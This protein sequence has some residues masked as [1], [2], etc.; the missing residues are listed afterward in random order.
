MLP[1]S[2]SVA[3]ATGCGPTKTLPRGEVLL[4][5]ADSSSDLLTIGDHNCS[6]FV[7]PYTVII[8]TRSGA[9]SQRA[10]HDHGGA[11]TDGSAEPRFSWCGRFRIMTG[12]Q[13]IE[14]RSQFTA[15]RSGGFQEGLEADAEVLVVLEAIEQGELID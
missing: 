1:S 4:H 15:S 13:L 5:C 9:A 2:T 3:R 11:A 8:P 12:P 10:A 7:I 6:K 14:A